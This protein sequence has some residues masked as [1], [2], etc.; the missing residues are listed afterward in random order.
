AVSFDFLPAPRSGEDVVSLKNVHKG[1]GNRSIYEGLDFMVSRRERWCVMGI[2]GA[3]KSTLLKLV[4]GATEP[5]DGTVA[6]GGSVKMGYFAQHAMDLLDGERTVFQ[7][8]RSEEH[9]SELQSPVH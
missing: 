9:T 2:N 1:Y 6:L 8:L 4:A 5:D 3:G 7:S